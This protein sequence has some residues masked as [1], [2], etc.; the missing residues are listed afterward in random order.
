M[1]TK[2]G[3]QLYTLREYLRTPSDIAKTLAE[4]RKI[5][6]RVVQVS[7]L[8]P[9]EPKELKRILDGEGLYACSTHTGYERLVNDIQ[10][11]IEEHEILGAKHIACPGLPKE[12]HNEEGYRKA[13][14]KLSEAGRVLKEHGFTLSY[15]NHA[16][17]FEKYGGKV[18]LEILLDS[19]DPDCLYAEIDTY[20]VQYGGGDPA[21]WCRRFA[22]RLPL[23]HLKDMGMKEGNQVMMEVGE[24]NLNWPE[25]LKA[26][27]E[28][29]TEWYLVE[30]DVCRRHPL[31]SLKISLENLKR[32][33]LE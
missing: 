10:G 4:L 18:G 1:E 13:A 11:V 20:W 8:G 33:G 15:H 17:E 5:G 27:G 26:C 21:Y 12:M 25:I 23:V 16:V 31:E 7:G 6:Y 29:G 28:A 30:Q 19:A 32:M 3:A 14:R 22:G 2:V 9:V 24:G